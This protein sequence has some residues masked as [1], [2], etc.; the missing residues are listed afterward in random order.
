MQTLVGP[1][2]YDFGLRA[3]PQAGFKLLITQ[4]SQIEQSL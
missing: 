4:A 1:G 2:K 3:E